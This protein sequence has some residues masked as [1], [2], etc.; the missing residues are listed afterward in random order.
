[1]GTWGVGGTY[2]LTPTGYTVTTRVR[3]SNV[4]LIVW[5]MS[6]DS[7]HRPQFNVP[8][9]VWAKSQDSVHRPQFNVSLTVW[10]RSQDKCP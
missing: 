7:V 4:S 8:L 9:T 6:Q 3:H 2:V 1:M 10:A 5:A